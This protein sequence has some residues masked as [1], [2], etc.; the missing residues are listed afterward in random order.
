MNRTILV[1]IDISDSE[2]TQRVISHV[3]AE[4]KID[5]AKV[6]FALFDCNP[7]FEV[8]FLTVIPSLPYYASLGL[9]YSAEL[10]AMDDLKAEAKSQL[11]AII[12]KFNLP[13]D[14]VQAHVAE[15][16]P[17]DKILEM[18]KKLPADMVIIASHRPDITTYLLGSNAAAVVRHAECSVLVVR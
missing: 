14:R 17:K 4:A 2:L 11:E 15:G 10:P 7:V 12:K 8:H 6:H 13:A 5:D 3:E 9:A 18:A 16:S 1:P